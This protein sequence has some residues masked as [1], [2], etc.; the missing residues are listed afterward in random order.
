MKQHIWSLEVFVHWSLK[1]IIGNMLGI[2][3]RVS[4]K[5]TPEVF[6][7]IANSIDY[8]SEKKNP[9]Q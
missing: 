8:P 9:L 7:E 2:D 4:D 6:V 5:V 3:K 1:E